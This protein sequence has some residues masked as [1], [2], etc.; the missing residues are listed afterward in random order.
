MANSCI[1]VDW[2][3]APEVFRD[4]LVRARKGHVCGECDEKILPGDLHEYAT[5]KWDGDWSEHR[6]CARCCNVRRDYFGSW[7]YGMLVED[8]NAE[9][10]I[11]YRHGIPAHITPCRGSTP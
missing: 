5:G 8:F 10:G 4:K 6:T 3:D 7:C 9:H 2:G 11:D 1:D